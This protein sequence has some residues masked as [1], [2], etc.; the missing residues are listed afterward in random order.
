MLLGELGLHASDGGFDEEGNQ[1]LICAIYAD[2]LEGGDI[3]STIF[4]ADDE[5]GM[6]GAKENEV[7]E[8][9]A[10]TSVSIAERMKVFVI[11]VPFGCDD[12]WVL[13]FIESLLC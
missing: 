9:A 6:I 12:Q 7:G 4:E 8:Q 10:R 13:S 1:M 2:L 5:Q 3:G 11:A